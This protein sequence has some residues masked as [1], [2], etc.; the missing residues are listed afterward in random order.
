MFLGNRYALNNSEIIDII[1]RT[2]GCLEVVIY[3]QYFT[4]DYAQTF[5]VNTNGRRL[6]PPLNKFLH[7]DQWPGYIKANWG[8]T[9]NNMVDDPTVTAHF[10]ETPTSLNKFF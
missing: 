6:Y 7:F 2:A 8:M 5:A 9:P 3:E 4:E 1:A 10:K